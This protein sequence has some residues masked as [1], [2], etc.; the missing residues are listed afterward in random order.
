MKKRVTVCI[1]IL[2]TI[3]SSIHLFAQIKSV[4]RPNVIVIL[5]DDQGTLDL[6]SYGAKDLKTPNL[7][8][9]AWVKEIVEQ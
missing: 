5:H 7:D 2:L 8:K 6:N 1:G 4:D 3:V 9:L